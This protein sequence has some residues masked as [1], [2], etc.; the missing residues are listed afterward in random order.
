[1]GQQLIVV[2]KT[3]LDIICSD[4]LAHGYSGTGIQASLEMNTVLRWI[5]RLLLQDLLKL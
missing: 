1:M 2:I 3:L 5:K 4:R